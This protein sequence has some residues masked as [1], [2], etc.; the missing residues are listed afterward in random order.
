[1]R[2]VLYNI[3]YG[4]GGGKSRLPWRGYLGRT[5]SNV[6]RIIGFLK[7]QQPDIVALVEVDAGSYRHGRACQAEAIAAALG[8]YHTFQSKY[9]HGS[10]ANLLP[11]LN[12]QGNAFLTRDTIRNTEFHYFDRGVKR[13]VIELE[14]EDLTVFLVHLALGPRV[15]HHQLC[16]LYSLVKDTPKPHIVAGDFNMLWG[17]REIELFLAATGL[18]SANRQHLPSF[19]S[20]HPRRQLDFILHSPQVRIERFEIPRVRHSDHLPLVCDFS[21]KDSETTSVA[22]SSSGEKAL[23]AV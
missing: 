17:D 23:V 5:H 9:A 15:R 1:M 19:P 8:H 10:L 20:R 3:R 2:L 16:E 7:Q 22:G 12:K 18:T 4:T 6:G 14:L 21:V 11:V 13:L